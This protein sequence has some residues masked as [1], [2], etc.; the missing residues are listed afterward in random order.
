MNLF[1]KPVFSKVNLPVIIIFLLYC[2]FSVIGMLHH[3]MWRDELQAWMVARDAD[4]FFDL[5][6]NLKYEGNPAL[7]HI[8]LFVLARFT[9]SPYSMMVLHLA[10]S[11]SFVFIFLFKSNFCML[12]KLLFV[13]GYFILFEYNLVSRSYGL[14]VLLV[15]LILSLYRD[16]RQ[17]MMLIFILMA[18]LAN[19]T[20]YGLILSG[21][22][23]L[24]LLS[25]EFFTEKAIQ[26]QV[27]KKK[28]VT[29]Q[30]FIFQWPLLKP[31]FYAGFL[32]YITGAVLSALQIYPEPNNTFPVH[33]PDPLFNLD[34][35]KLICANVMNAF[36]PVPDFSGSHFWNSDYIHW[37]SFGWTPLFFMLL[38]VIG[39]ITLLTSVKSNMIIRVK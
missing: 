19:T 15:F 6:R 22:F 30:K 13:S 33:S 35:L 11:F 4:S 2:I 8:L 10:I 32:I 28:T 12:H 16:R 36:F 31:A 7:W 34:R 18:L 17:K 24:L 1:R 21:A 29:K 23:A 26:V 27:S 3:E 5:L 9:V 14:G 38:V 37:N 20:V 25:E 39:L